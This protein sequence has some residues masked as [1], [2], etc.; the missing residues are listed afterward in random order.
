MCDVFRMPTGQ[1]EQA[2]NVSNWVGGVV[3]LGYSG[4]PTFSESYFC[5]GYHGLSGDGM[6]LTRRGDA[7]ATPDGSTR[8]TESA[9]QRLLGLHGDSYKFLLL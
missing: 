8:Q 7:G 3:S 4:P 2:N 6:P 5:S 9:T 1:T